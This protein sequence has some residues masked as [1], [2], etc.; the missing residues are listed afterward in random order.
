MGDAFV[1]GQSLD[2]ENS[3][4]IVR[5]G[6]W[7][8]DRDLGVTIDAAAVDA[9]A[10]PNTSLRKGLVVGANSAGKFLEAVNAAVVGPTAHSEDSVAETFDMSG[11]PT[12]TLEVDGESVVV[13]FADADFSVPTAAT[14]AEVVAVLIDP[15]KGGRPDLYL[16]EDVSGVVRITANAKGSG[17]TLRITG[18]AANTALQFGTVG[19]TGTDGDFGI[20]KFAHD[21][22][23]KSNTAVDALNDIMR[24]GEMDESLCIGLTADAKKALQSTGCVFVNP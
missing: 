17:H 6:A 8:Y 3:V 7:G 10:T 13:Q 21:T 4:P 1:P 24:A 2:A 5:V 19:G 23:D 14:A 15:A 11:D 18:G 9:G 16:A 12:L 20:L 22:L